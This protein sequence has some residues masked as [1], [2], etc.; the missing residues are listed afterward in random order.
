MGAVGFEPP[1]ITGG[2]K[3]HLRE[4]ATQG[5]ADSGAV[6][7]QTVPDDRDLRRIVA[8]WSTLPEPIKAAISQRW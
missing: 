5:A 7:R 8:A 3:K 4:S 2:D 6:E 1:H